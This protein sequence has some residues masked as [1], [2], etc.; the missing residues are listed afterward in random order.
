LKLD[1]IVFGVIPGLSHPS[2]VRGLKLV[3]KP[4]YPLVPGVAPLAG[5]WIETATT[6]DLVGYIYVAPLAGAWIETTYLSLLA[7]AQWRRT[8]R[9]CVD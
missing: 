1:W 5:A 2:R 3:I 4:G 9:G 7:S 6:Y 8:P